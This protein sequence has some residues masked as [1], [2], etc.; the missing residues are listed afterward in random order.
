MTKEYPTNIVGIKI[1]FVTEGDEP[2]V[3]HFIKAIAEYENMS[4][5]VVATEEDL[6]K[7]IFEQRA[8][9]VLL[10]EHYG[11]PVGFC[12]YF[13]TFSTFCGRRNLYLEDLFINED[14]RGIGIGH[15]VFRIL[16]QIAL[17]EGCQRLEWVCLNWNEPSIRFYQGLGA[18]PLKEWT[19][20]RMTSEDMKQ[21]LE[22]KPEIQ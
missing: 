13:H 22:G 2:T 12:L 5:C 11:A 14:M 7:A 16:M 15:E 18:T 3:L 8:C 21:A 1:R 6:H 10:I 4:E 19:T 17:T 9:N 20:W